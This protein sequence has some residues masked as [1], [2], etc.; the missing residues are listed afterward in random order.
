MKA[1]QT[2]W[3]NGIN[4][5]HIRVSVA[6]HQ[7]PAMISL[8]PRRRRSSDLSSIHSI[9]SATSGDVHVLL[10]RFDFWMQWNLIA[11][12]LQVNLFSRRRGQ[13]APDWWF[14]HMW[15]RPFFVTRA[16][17]LIVSILKLVSRQILVMLQDRS[18][19]VHVIFVDNAHF[20]LPLSPPCPEC[21][22]ETFPFF[23]DEIVG[24]KCEPR[25]GASA[26]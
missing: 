1:I 14:M 19:I 6:T 23:G 5:F 17:H 16:V 21:K 26:R 10:V 18:S 20:L 4:R 24:A 8:P 9:P 3:V 15:Y 25:E 12:F 11:Q 2:S 7:L 13:I 22:Q